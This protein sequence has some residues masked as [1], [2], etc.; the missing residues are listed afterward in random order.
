MRYLILITVSL[1]MLLSSLRLVQAQELAATLEVLEPVVEVQRVNTA[2]WVP[3]NIES[4]VGVGDM[5]RTG[6][7]GR[8]RIT[9]FADGV[10]TEL[11]PNTTYSIQ[12]FEGDETRFTIEAEV[13]I[14]QTTQRLGELLDAN[15]NYDINTPGMQLVARGTEFDI[16]VE[17]DGRAAMLVRE[18]SVDANAMDT[19]ADVDP[20][21]G[22][23]SAVDEIIS[24]VVAAATFEQLDAALDGCGA[25][26]TTQDDV[27]LNVRLGPNTEF[28]RVGTIAPADVDLFIG[29]VEGD[30]WYRIHYREGFGWILASDVTVV[31]D[32]V[33]LRLFPTSHGP[34]DPTLFTELGD[35]ITPDDLDAIVPPPQPEAD[36]TPEATTE[37]EQ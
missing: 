22:V 13:L 33:G 19:T 4:V 11:Q 30:N 14:G 26:V 27:R 20:G 8:A 37:P 24:D 32:C 7:A 34:E 25:S 29:V 15:S 21:F 35:A 16:R 1:T 2:N 10:D 17:D 9:F 28:P 31:S 6:E 12:R 18:G 5:I 23:R 36:I 3:I